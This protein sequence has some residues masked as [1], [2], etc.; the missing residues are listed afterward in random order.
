MFLRLGIVSIIIVCSHIAH[1]SN[2]QWPTN[3]G[4]TTNTH[5]S[6]LKQI[7]VD[8][9]KQLKQAWVFHTGDSS[10]KT[11]GIL[12]T[13]FEATPI[14]ANNKLYLCTPFNN[15][16][17][18]DPTSGKEI[19]RFDSLT[20]LRITSHGMLKC[21]GIS[22]WQAENPVKGE[23]C[24]RRIFAGTMGGKFY[25]LDADT[26]R[27]CENFGDQGV[28][29]FNYKQTN[30][31]KY[32]HYEKNGSKFT[33]QRYTYNFISPSMVYK[34]LVITGNSSSD[35][36]LSNMPDGIIWAMDAVTGEIKWRF[37]PIPK[38]LR[39]KTGAANSWSSMAL[40][41]ERGIIYVPTASPSPDYYG[42][43][44]TQPMPYANALIALKA[45]TGKVLWH[46]QTV[47]HNLWDYDLASPPILVDFKRDGKTIP[48]VVQTAKTGFTFVFN[49]VTGEPLFPIK[50]VPVPQSDIPGEKTSPTQPIPE[51]PEHLIPIKVKKAWGMILWDKYKCQQELDKYDNKGIFT[52]PSLRGALV[53]PSYYG[54]SNWGGGAFDANTNLLIVNT[55]NVLGLVKL[56]PK[57]DFWKFKTENPSYDDVNL[58]QGAPY[59]MARKLVS[60]PFG[61]PC[62]APPWGEIAGIN[63]TTGKIEWQHP[64]GSVKV[65]GPFHSFSKWGSPTLGG[66]IITASNLIFI[67]STLDSKLHVFDLKSGKLLWQADLPAP[68]VATPM[69]YKINGK[70]Y[71]VIA[72]GRDAP[73]GGKISDALVAFAL[74]ESA[75]AK[76]INAK[77]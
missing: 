4:Q 7:T 59:A 8:N 55:I 41:K 57:K 33:I 31:D 45:E 35:N 28:I 47:H 16:I 26:G 24:Q 68:G 40:D 73:R 23:A 63:L 67:G 62:V 42:G 64:I 46:F 76:S 66:P 19:W 6:P 11:K 3:G 20:N 53:Y 5:Y 39:D 77:P 25:S 37:N 34:N 72:T 50:E 60:S 70:Q 17:A 51:L 2:T 49:R 22:Y 43:F 12:E 71:I 58:Q 56:L 29:D 32:L 10:P 44:R 52:P 1:A 13:A 15:V 65:F 48:A 61:V 38:E 36:V 54:G 30:G 14:L 75:T 69:T 9:V 74:P 18:I 27:P 21:R